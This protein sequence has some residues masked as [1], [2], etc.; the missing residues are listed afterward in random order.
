MAG[1]LVLLG[2]SI[3]DNGYYV[4]GGPS[5]LEH[6]RRLLPQAWQATLLAVD[7]AKIDSVYRQLER[8]PADATHLILSIGGNNALWFAGNVFPAEARTVRDAMETIAAA[9]EEFQNE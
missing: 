8:L 6:V 9:R 3:F 2:D 4:P 1:H 7:G 5:V